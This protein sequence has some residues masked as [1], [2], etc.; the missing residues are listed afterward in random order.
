M[1]DGN[2]QVILVPLLAALAFAGIVMAL[3]YPYISGDKA[4]EKRVASVSENRTKK[5]NARQTVDAAANRKKAVADTLKDI[6]T[7]QKSKEKV[8]LRN[9]LEQAGLEPDT[10]PFWI[11]SAVC[12]GICGLLVYTSLSGAAAPIAAA[13]AAF[14]GTLGLPRF[15]LKKLIARRQKKFLSELA[16]SID[17][18]VRG[19]KSGLPLNECLQI[20]AREGPEPIRTEFREVVEQQ[21]VGVPLGEALERLTQ[22]MPLSEV[23]FLTIVVAIQQQAGGNL[24]EALGNLSSV[25]R[26]RFRMSMKVQAL[27]AE[28]KASAGVLA[29]LPPGVLAMLTMS[30]PAYIKPLYTTTTGNFLI[31]AGLCWMLCGVLIMRKMINFKF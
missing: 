28:A 15:I 29:C 21:R 8:T 16:N 11:A 1:A 22:R 9:Q 23:K 2:L 19:V 3:V 30:S 12:G 26:D 14:V 24:S 17:V 25:L 13:T 20:I 10:K 7:R 5:I 31:G 4:V 6:E 27:A 18:I